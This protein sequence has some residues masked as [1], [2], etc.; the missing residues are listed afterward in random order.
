M[1]HYTYTVTLILLSSKV[2]L[3]YSH[4]LKEG[5]ICVVIAALFSYQ[6]SFYSKYTSINIQLSY[7][8][9]L[10]QTDANKKDST[11]PFINNL[12]IIEIFKDEGEEEE[13]SVI[14][15]IK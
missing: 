2:I 14:D 7:D 12:E 3:L 4:C 5:L 1:Q 13:A 10:V 8:V 11:V 6:P 9:Y 15:F